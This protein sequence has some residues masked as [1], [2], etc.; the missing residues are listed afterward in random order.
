MSIKVR[1]WL[2]ALGLYG[3]TTHEDRLEIDKEVENRTGVNC[4]Y[5]IENK[6]IDEEE[7]RRIVM[8][9]IR[10]RKQALEKVLDKMAKEKVIV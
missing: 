2:R 5:A 1:E 6:M 7:F 9:V 3:Q 8:L 4:D 10:W